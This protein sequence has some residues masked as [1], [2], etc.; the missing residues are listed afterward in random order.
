MDVVIKEIGGSKGE[1]KGNSVV[2]VRSS[3]DIIEVG[4]QPARLESWRE[5]VEPF[6]YKSFFL[7]WPAPSRYCLPSMKLSFMLK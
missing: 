6:V 7:L 2:A 1:E 3:Q 5:D 4:M